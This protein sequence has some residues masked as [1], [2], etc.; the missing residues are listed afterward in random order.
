MITFVTHLQVKPENVAAYEDL[1]A[2]VTSMTR[3]HEPGVVHYDWA[4]SVDEPGTYVVIEV[5]RDAEAQA[6]HLASAWIAE[7]LPKS[8]ALIEGTPSIR[9]YTGEG[10]QPVRSQMNF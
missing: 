8:M 6:A 5:Y 1:L 7:S 4:R 3:E 9:Q 2:H 10:S